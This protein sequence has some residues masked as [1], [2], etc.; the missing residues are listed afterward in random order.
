[1]IGMQK[2]L[3]AEEKL[4]AGTHALLTDLEPTVGGKGS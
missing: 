1:M 3:L 2:E 4:V